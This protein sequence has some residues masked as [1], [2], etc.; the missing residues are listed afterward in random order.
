MTTRQER[1]D[2]T[3]VFWIAAI[4]AAGLLITWQMSVSWPHNYDEGFNYFFFGQR[5]FRFTVD[6][7][8]YP[9]NHILFSLI[10]AAIP[11]S[12]VDAEPLALRIPNLFISTGLL[13]V[14]TAQARRRWTGL[15]MAVALVLAGPWS[16][17]FFPVARGYQLG[18]LLVAIA[19][20]ITARWADAAWT[21]LVAALLMA[22]AA[23]TVPTFAFGAP[24]LSIWWAMRR[25]WRPAAVYSSVFVVLAFLLYLPVLDQLF[26]E[27]TS[28]RNETLSLTRFARDLTRE[29]FFLPDW[30]ALIIVGLGG[31][32][33]FEAGRRQ[34]ARTEDTGSRWSFLLLG[35]PLVFV[36]V[37]ELLPRVTDVSTPFFRNAAFASL[38]IPVGIW[39]SPV[40]TRPIVKI[41]LVTLLTWNSV[42]GL[43]LYLGV[44]DGSRIVDYEGTFIGQTP[45]LDDVLADED[46]AE[47]RCAWTDE[48]TCR[49]YEKHFQDRGVLVTP[50][51]EI[52]EA[53]ECAVGRYPPQ[54]GTGIDLIYTDGHR[55]LVCFD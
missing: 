29:L 20:L 53:T 9:N 34:L 42:L 25:Q 22:L 30:A 4:A 32:A 8:T 33:L 21:P 7:Y 2:R 28:G 54:A 50:F 48:W 47:I 35:Y 26:G 49:L 11:R 39:V 18:A 40:W 55:G 36:L 46:L 27:T 1:P 45:R 41:L 13:V 5:G 14:L 37:A 31:W 43:N 52:I 24:V 23:W 16:I 3:Q 44:T 15:P 6:N 17:I 10:Q 12:L 51:V 38:F 19:L